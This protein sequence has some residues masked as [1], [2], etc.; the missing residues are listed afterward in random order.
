M[1]RIAFLIIFCAFLGLFGCS[2][3]KSVLPVSSDSV[4]ETPKI[5]E[6]VLASGKINLSISNNTNKIGVTSLETKDATDVTVDIGNLTNFEMYNS[7]RFSVSELDKVEAGGKIL[8]NIVYNDLAV[9]NSD[10]KLKIYLE[11]SEGFVGVDN[12]SSILPIYAKLKADSNYTSVSSTGFALK[13]WGKPDEGWSQPI[14]EVLEIKLQGDFKQAMKQ[15][16]ATKLCID[17]VEVATTP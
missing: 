6:T 10:Y 3:T 14:D 2:T 15:A 5:T 4:V 9:S 8:L 12:S 11:N 7:V 13:T 17:F 1:K 16:Y